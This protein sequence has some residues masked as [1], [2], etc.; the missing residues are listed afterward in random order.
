VF[1]DTAEGRTT[2]TWAQHDHAG[3]SAMETLIT[4]FGRAFFSEYELLKE[5]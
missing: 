4:R 1:S 2:K 5:I 3:F